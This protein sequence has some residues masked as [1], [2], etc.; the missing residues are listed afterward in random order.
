MLSRSASHD[1]HPQCGAAPAIPPI[2][3]VERRKV[4]FN[5][6]APDMLGER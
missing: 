1:P 6:I 5:R 3:M 2:G 4:D